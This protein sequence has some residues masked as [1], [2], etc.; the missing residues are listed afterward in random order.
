MPLIPPAGHITSHS[1]SGDDEK[2]V[3]TEEEEECKESSDAEQNTESN[4][5]E[6]PEEQWTQCP[7]P[8]KRGTNCTL[9]LLFVLLL[10][11]Q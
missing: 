8:A 4:R 2:E 11:L 7:D 3:F 1:L 6:I 9:L 5:E 10:L